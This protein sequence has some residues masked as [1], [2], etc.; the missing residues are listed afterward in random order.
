LAGGAAGPLQPAAVDTPDIPVSTGVLGP[1]AVVHETELA[2]ANVFG[3]AFA[4]TQVV[5]PVADP[6][7]SQTQKN[8]IFAQRKL[9]DERE[10]TNAATR[11]FVT[12]DAKVKAFATETTAGK[13]VP[14]H[15]S[16]AAATV[17]AQFAAN[18]ESAQRLFDKVAVASNGTEN[19]TSDVRLYDKVGQPDTQNQN[20]GGN[21]G[22]GDQ[23]LDSRQSL[24]QR[25]QAVAQALGEKSG[26][27]AVKKLV[28]TLE[29]Y[30]VV[31]KI[32]PGRSARPSVRVI[33]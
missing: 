1:A 11:K 13:F 7:P 16:V 19:P 21:E 30:A 4:P 26:N 9:F 32:G 24:Y 25:A 27:P 33:A 8:F 28:A 12:D 15:A 18:A 29:A 31:A 5:Q 3:A 2:T 20:N 22:P 23:A 6:V 10:I 17:G 14:Q